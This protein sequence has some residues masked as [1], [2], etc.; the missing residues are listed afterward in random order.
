MPSTIDSINLFKESKVIFLPA[1]AANA[2]GVAVSGLEMAQN[3]MGTPWTR[4]K[5]DDKLQD[6]MS[7]IHEACVAHGRV[8]GE[9]G[10]DYT[11]GANVAGFIKVAEAM[12]AYGIM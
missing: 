10:I 4:K 7:N 9:D 5:V 2:G 8:K 12:L 3:S 11:H 6:I 1:K